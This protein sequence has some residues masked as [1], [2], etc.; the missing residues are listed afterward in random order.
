MEE[1]EKRLVYEHKKSLMWK[2]RRNEKIGRSGS[3]VEV[4]RD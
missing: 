2:E 4:D 3:K 1:D